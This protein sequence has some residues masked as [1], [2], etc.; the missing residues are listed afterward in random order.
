[1]QEI[2]R[3]EEPN[4]VAGQ[5]GGRQEEQEQERES[6]VEAYQALNMP[7]QIKDSEMELNYKT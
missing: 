7:L 3:H 4:V 1:M 5:E 6:T 2:E